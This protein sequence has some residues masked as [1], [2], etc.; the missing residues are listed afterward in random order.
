[1]R[2]AISRFTI[3]T[4]ASR[5]PNAR[6][7]TIGNPWMPKYPGETGGYLRRLTHELLTRLATSQGDTPVTEAVPVGDMAEQGGKR[8]EGKR[9]MFA[10]WMERRTTA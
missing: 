10:T 1:M 9:G 8:G 2:R 6:P 7:S 5:A 4:P 3:A